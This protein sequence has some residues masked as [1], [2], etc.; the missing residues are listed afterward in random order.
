MMFST[1]AIIRRHSFESIYDSKNEINTLNKQ[2]AKSR[3]ENHV[4]VW[5][6]RNF[7]R[8]YTIA[9]LQSHISFILTY[10]SVIRF[11]RL[12]EFS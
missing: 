9:Q 2:P 6:C 11:Y 1:Y 12:F 8:L 3:K 4:K 5:A 7:I 10:I